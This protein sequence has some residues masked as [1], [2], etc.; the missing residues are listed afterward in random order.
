MLVNEKVAVEHGEEVNTALPPSYGPRRV[1]V[2]AGPS[3]TA[4]A[5]SMGGLSTWD[6]STTK[7][8]PP[9]PPSGESLSGATSKQSLAKS[10][11]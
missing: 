4:S 8:T 10:G 2:G 6:S 3:M 9:P 5:P 7:A 11:W 1:T